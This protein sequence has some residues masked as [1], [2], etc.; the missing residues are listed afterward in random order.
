[1]LHGKCLCEAITYQ[2]D[3]NLGP[4]FHCHC[5]KCR[6][7]HGAAF[8]TRASI[9]KSQ[10]TW[11]TGEENLSAYPS[12]NNV[13]KFF[14]KTCG[15]PLIS[16]YVDRPNVLGVPLGGLEGELSSKPEAHIFTNS[17]ADW[18]EITDDIPQYPK[19]PGNEAKV[20]EMDC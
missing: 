8:R 14:C 17:K 2:I 3:G 19:W 16:T 11:L 13:T 9:N 15:S 5:S 12:S 7:W 18:H 4:I 10:F 1:M 20:R 6:R